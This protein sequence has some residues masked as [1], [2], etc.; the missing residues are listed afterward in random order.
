MDIWEIVKGKYLS[1]LLIC[2]LETLPFFNLVTMDAFICHPLAA[3][4]LV[5]IEL[6]ICELDEHDGQQFLH[7]PLV[8]VIKAHRSCSFKRFTIVVKVYLLLM[9]G[10]IRIEMDTHE[11]D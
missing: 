8:V 6:R 4:L 2:F 5:H 1:S 7:M 3:H 9:G 11:V 10:A